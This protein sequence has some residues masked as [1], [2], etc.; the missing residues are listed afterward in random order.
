MKEGGVGGAN[1]QTGAV[2][3]GKV[4]LVTFLKSLSG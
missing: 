2:F 4:D 3:E 1:T